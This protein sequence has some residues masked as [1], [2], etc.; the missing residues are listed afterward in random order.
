MK[1]SAA[2]LVPSVIQRCVATF[3]VGQFISET[4]YRLPSTRST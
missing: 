4:R 1:P 3:H 2:V